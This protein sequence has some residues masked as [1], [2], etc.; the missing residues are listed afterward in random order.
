M[1]NEQISPELL[2]K[3]TAARDVVLDFRRGQHH[4]ERQSAD[5]ATWADR[6][7]YALI[8]VCG[9]AEGRTEPED[10][11]HRPVHGWSRRSGDV[12]A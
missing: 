4:P 5:A 6:L 1:M 7:A 11:C 8:E 12:S 10:G 9:A 2:D 3:I